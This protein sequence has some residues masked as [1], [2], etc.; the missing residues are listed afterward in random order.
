MS[1]DL[2]LDYDMLR[3]NRDNIRGIAELMEEPC[4]AMAE[5]DGASMGVSR[6]ERRMDDF[7]EEWEYGISQL[8][9]FADNAADGLDEI[10]RSFQAIDEGLEACLREE[11][12]EG[13][14]GDLAA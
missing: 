14:G 2:Y 6:L 13:D 4:R 8:A 3:A 5:V 9:E 7:G 11:S 10:L 1:S 12:T